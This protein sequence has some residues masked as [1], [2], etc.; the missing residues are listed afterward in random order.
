MEPSESVAPVAEGK[1]SFDPQHAKPCFTRWLSTSTA[2]AV[3]AIQLGIYLGPGGLTSFLW[4]G[5]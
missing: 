2:L 5:C 3:R 4:G 1:T